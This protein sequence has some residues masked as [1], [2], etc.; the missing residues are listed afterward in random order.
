MLAYQF[1]NLLKLKAL[2]EKNI[3]YYALAKQANLH[4]FVVKK[5]QDQLRNFSLAQLKKI[6]R[7]LSQIDLAIKTGR[8]DQQTAL[9]LL[10]A[11]I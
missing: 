9:D 4:P 2:S 6:Y 5:S 1:R 10:V 11:E 3:P 7:Q 8:L